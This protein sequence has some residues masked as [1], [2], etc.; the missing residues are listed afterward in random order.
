MNTITTPNLMGRVA[1]IVEEVSAST[2]IDDIDAEVIKKI[3]QDSLNEY[4][5]MV[6]EYYDEEYSNA[7]NSMR[8]KAY[9]IGYDDGYSLGYDDGY[10]DGQSA[11]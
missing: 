4:C 2:C 8:S 10:L 11:E 1:K 3:L 7:L 9:D 5:T 6:N